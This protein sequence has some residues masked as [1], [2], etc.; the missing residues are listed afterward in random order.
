ME[1]IINF[2]FNYS[3]SHINEDDDDKGAPSTGRLSCD[4][5]FATFH[6]YLDISQKRQNVM[7]VVSMER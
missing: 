1:E 3:G 4:R 5:K 7:I 6:R 2:S